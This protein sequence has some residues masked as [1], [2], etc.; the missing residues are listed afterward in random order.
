[1][2]RG[3]GGD[4]FCACSDVSSIVVV[5]VVVICGNSELAARAFVSMHFPRSFPEYRV[6]VPPALLLHFG[7][8]LDLYIFLGSFF[9]NQGAWSS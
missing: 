7:I 6:L 9:Q 1:M 3:R 2:R 5:V 8:A 4:S